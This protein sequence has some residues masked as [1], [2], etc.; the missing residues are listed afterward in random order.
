MMEDKNNKT[1]KKE[2][3]KKSF[4][5]GLWDWVK[6]FIYALVLALIIKTFIFEPTEVHGE[7]MLNT[8]HHGDRLIVN[9]IS[10]KFDLLKRGEIIVLHFNPTDEDYIKRI[11]G[12]PGDTVQLIDGNFY[13]NKKKLVEDYIS[14]DYTYPIKVNEQTGTN[15]WVLKD[16]EYFVAGDNRNPGKSSDSRDF[17]PVNINDI[18]GV[19]RL[20]FYPFGKSLGWLK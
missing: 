7:S 16:G 17:G 3:K 12:I 5:L 15:E 9:K 6:S 2:D 14:G 8:L 1:E 19:A 10:L 18:K 11:I 13:I 20:R 4:L